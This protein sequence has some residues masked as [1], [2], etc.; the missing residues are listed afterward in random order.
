[1]NEERLA[2]LWQF[3]EQLI[4]K[5]IDDLPGELKRM[6][7][8]CG[9][10]GIGQYSGEARDQR[11]DIVCGEAS[12]WIDGKFSLWIGFN[13]RVRDYALK[14]VLQHE[15]AHIAFYSQMMLDLGL[16]R[17]SDLAYFE[18]MRRANR[19]FDPAY[20]SHGAVWRK[21]YARITGRSASS[22]RH[23]SQPDDRVSAMRWGSLLPKAEGEGIEACLYGVY[24]DSSYECSS[25]LLMCGGVLD[26]LEREA[27]SAKA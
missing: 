13:G 9:G 27:E 15:L 8:E 7:A 19:K 23:Y 5:T 17:P 12:A 4:Q 11:F 26:E 16:Y 24:L 25:T 1:M 6:I 2:T 3:R 18:A 10:V 21:M 20:S 22:A 14:E